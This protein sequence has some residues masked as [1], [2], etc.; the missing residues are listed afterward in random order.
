MAEWMLNLGPLTLNAVDL[1]IVGIA[2][3]A[4]IVGAAKGFAAE[5]GSRLGFIVG[6]ILAIV[7]AE[8]GAQ[9]LEQ[10]FALG[11]LWST[12][13]AYVVLFIVGYI[14]MMIVGSLL[15][16]ALKTLKAL[17]LD[18]LLGFFLGAAE[19]LI[20]IGLLIMLLRMQTVGDVAPFVDKSL[21]ANF[22]TPIINKGVDLGKGLL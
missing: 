20:I 5:F 11:L 2:V 6:I 7:F 16:K 4:A 9:L 10:T 8:L 15:G 18:H 22:I 17:W 14:L 1:I 3:L 13:I 21:I 19:A 12:L